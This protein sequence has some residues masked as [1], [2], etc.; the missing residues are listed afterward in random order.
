[1]NFTVSVIIPAFNAERT[2][3]ATLASAQA[4]T[5]RDLEI[6]VVDDGS[7]DRTAQ[8]AQTFAND[9]CRI[10]VFTKDNGGVADARNFG[11][12]RARGEYLAFLDAD[13]LWHP[14]KL[15]LQ[16]DLFARAGADLGLVYNWFHFIDEDGRILRSSV[17]HRAEGRV[18][19]RHLDWNFISNGSTI[20][21]PAALAR[22]VRFD[23][24]MMGGGSQGCEDYL[25]QLKIARTH[26]F[27]VVAAFLTGYR[28]VHG[29]MSHESAPMI[30][31]HMQALRAVRELEPGLAR[32]IDRRLAE[33][34]IEYARNRLRRGHLGQG[35]A[36]LA[37][38]MCKAPRAAVVHAVRQA[39]LRHKFPRGNGGLALAGRDFLEVDPF[40]PAGRA[41][42][43]W[44]ERRWAGLPAQ[45]FA[46]D[47]IAP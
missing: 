22:E 33:F 18:L 27:G 5:L 37:D 30:G 17:M 23:T 35:L 32:V 47:P 36:S 28:R 14:R 15:E 4:Q 26:T 41:M 12:D 3:A 29:S 40:E 24:A 45:S 9:D 21:V 1:M 39:G 2:L 8:M 11:I 10:R 42:P 34:Q 19:P 6:L 46:A 25:F 38:A 44:R 16:H 43:A 20:M 31:F 7:S 13:D